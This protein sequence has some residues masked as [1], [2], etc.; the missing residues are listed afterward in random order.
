VAGSDINDKAMWALFTGEQQ[1]SRTFRTEQEAWHQAR[2]CGLADGDILE[3]GYVIR[4]IKDRK[5][6]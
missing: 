6:A 3:H 4:R 1:V 5:A 2:K